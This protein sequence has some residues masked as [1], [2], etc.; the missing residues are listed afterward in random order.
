M[1]PLE[2]QNEIKCDLK[3]KNKN[4]QQFWMGKLTPGG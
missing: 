4:Y 3:E 2:E 1:K